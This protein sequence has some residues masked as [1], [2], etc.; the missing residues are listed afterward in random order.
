MRYS[1][2]FII[3]LFIIFSC[4]ERIDKPLK[5]INSDLLVV[6]AIL[7][8]EN[9]N[10][11]IVLS[12]PYQNLNEMVAPATGA[13][14][15]IVEG[16]STVYSAVENPVGS[17]N[18]FT[19]KM[20]AVFGRTYTL[21]IQ[22][23]GKSYFAQGG[24][25]PVEPL[26]P[27]QYQR[28]TESQYRL[29]IGDSGSDPNFVD[30]SMRWNNTSF[31]QPGSLCEGRVVYYDLKSI[32]VNSLFKPDQ[33]DFVFPVGT[34][35]IRKKYSV[36]LGYKAFLRSLLSETEWRGGL[37]DIQRANVTS[38]L[39]EGAIGYFTVSSVVSDTTLIIEKP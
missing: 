5:S 6:E 34:I 15:Y 39:S 31:C 29:L 1:Y 18:Y 17:G 38:N 10:Q 7:T 9:I 35:V 36:S 24:S 28:A 32:D 33:S 13:T 4:E 14:I 19:E 8:N 21:V 16:G 11:K 12:Y 23:K 3:I 30:H 20:T 22:L 2:L 25:V 37:F 27:L 26:A